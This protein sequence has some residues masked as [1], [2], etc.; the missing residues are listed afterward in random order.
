MVLQHSRIS[1]DHDRNRTDDDRA[2]GDRMP[3]AADEPGDSAA[4]AEHRESPDAGYASARLLLSQFPA[5]F[6]ADQQAA[7]ERRS[8]AQR[9]PVPAGVQRNRSACQARWSAMKVEM[10]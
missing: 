5:A 2:A 8:D 10:K 7:G 1:G 4:E 6:D 9:L 3:E